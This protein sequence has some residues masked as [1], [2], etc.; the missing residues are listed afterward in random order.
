MRQ[1]KLYLHLPEYISTPDSMDSDNEGNLILSCPN[2]AEPTTSGCVV[3]ISKGERKVTKWFDC[4]VHP[5]TGVARNMGIAVVHQWDELYD[6]YICDNQGWSGKPEVMFKGR[7]LKVTMDGDKMV[8][9]TTVAYNMEHP[10]GVR[11][12]D[13]YVYMTQSL[14]TRVKDPSGKLVSGV[15]RFAV[16][17]E[18]IDIKNTLDDPN[19][20]CHYLT[21][22][23]N[24]QY[25]VDGIAF[26]KNGRLYIGNFGD[27]EVFRITL[28]PDGSVAENALWAKNPDQLQTTD[29]M[30]FDDDGNLYIA[31]F[32]ANAIARV[33]PDGMTVTRLAQS[34][35]KSGFA[36]GLEQPGE[37]IVYD[38]KIIASCF[39]L[40]TGPGKINTGHEMPATL[41]YLEL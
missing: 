8:K 24:D 33:S 12:L 21:N 1:P 6:I 11:Y 38:G 5:D 41:A 39:D 14:M 2:F 4:P 25:G 31:D 28:T 37:P 29:G 34:P 19:L 40:V 17:E 3:K 32:S 15:Y 35:D 16:D 30:M 10:N 20:L 26:D 7:L 18:N 36:G 9:W 23:P 22:N 13:G 27:G